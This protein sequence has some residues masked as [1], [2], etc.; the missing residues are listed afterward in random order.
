M[1]EGI[2]WVAIAALIV[3]GFLWW[4]NHS[5]LCDAQCRE[6]QA[7]ARE[8]RLATKTSQTDKTR[9]RGNL[10]VRTYAGGPCTGRST[11]RRGVWKVDETNG[12]LGCWVQ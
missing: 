1:S 4:N 9:S 5:L 2:K 10:A 6:T 8:D 11:G 12:R 7:E 3:V